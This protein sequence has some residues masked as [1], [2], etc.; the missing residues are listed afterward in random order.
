MRKWLSFVWRVCFFSYFTSA[1][2][3]RWNGRTLLDV[4]HH[5]RVL[6]S[7]VVPSLWSSSFPMC[8]SSSNQ[9]PIAINSTS[10]ML[11]QTPALLTNY[12]LFPRIA[13]IVNNGNEFCSFFL[14]CEGHFLEIDVMQY[15]GTLMGSY[16]TSSYRLSKVLF[17]PFSLVCNSFCLHW[18]FCRY[19]FDPPS[20]IPRVS[21]QSMGC[22]ERWRF[23][24][25]I[26]IHT[27][28]R[29]KIA[30]T[31]TVRRYPT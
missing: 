29:F 12:P 24:F 13:F 19:L 21:I 17:K 22:M 31:T 6:M 4:S 14:S 26:L 10:T 7:Q 3:V 5:V 25:C 16:L 23:S 1:T 11:Q 15:N 30:L 20:T 9:S 2:W 8:S 27:I 18:S 28:L